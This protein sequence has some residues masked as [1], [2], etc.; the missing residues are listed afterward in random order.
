VSEALIRHCIGCDK[1]ITACNGFQLARD[2]IAHCNKERTTIRELCGVCALKAEMNPQ[3]FEQVVARTAAIQSP[4]AIG[5][6]FF[7]DRGG[8]RV[9]R[10]LP[11]S[12]APTF[13]EGL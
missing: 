8:E 2:F 3:W 9:A 4:H 1:E 12:V 11:I 5:Q 13:F 10:A 6:R 7:P